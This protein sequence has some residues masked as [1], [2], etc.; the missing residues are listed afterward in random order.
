M[1]A[2]VYPRASTYP[3]LSS[4]SL[5]LLSLTVSAD[6]L[7]IRADVGKGLQSNASTHGRTVEGT[8]S[9]ETRCTIKRIHVELHRVLGGE[10]VSLVEFKSALSACVRGG[11][12]ERG[13]GVIMK[14]ST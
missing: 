4:P 12:E 14:T 8:G 11:G 10:V 6:G 5:D 2:L 7:F 3:P 9:A 1:Q 13:G